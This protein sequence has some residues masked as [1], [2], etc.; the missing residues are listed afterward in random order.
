MVA[1]EDRNWSSGEYRK[2]NPDLALNRCKYC[3]I[4]P[5][6]LHHLLPRNEYPSLTYHPE[7]VIPLCVQI[8]GLITRKKLAKEQLKKY[9]SA[10]KKWRFTKDGRKTAVFDGVMK[11]LHQSIYGS[12]IDT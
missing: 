7:N 9:Q 11:E 8:H 4:Q 2:R 6:D 3:G 1:D 12:D 5:V 10:I